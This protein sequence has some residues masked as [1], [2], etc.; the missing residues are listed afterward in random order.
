M[1]PTTSMTGDRSSSRAARGATAA[2]EEERTRTDTETPAWLAAL[3]GPR[4]YTVRGQPAATGN[5]AASLR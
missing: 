1:W 4:A 5:G 3:S 2:A